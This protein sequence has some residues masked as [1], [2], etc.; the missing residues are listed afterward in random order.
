M[1]AKDLALLLL[2]PA[3]ALLLMVRLSAEDLPVLSPDGSGSGEVVSPG[4]QSGDDTSSKRDSK[5]G[6]PS[7]MSAELGEEIAKKVDKVQEDQKK[8]LE[9]LEELRKEMDFLKASVRTR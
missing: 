6:A 1:K 2:V 7:I 9:K 8:I 3:F 4:D 5:S